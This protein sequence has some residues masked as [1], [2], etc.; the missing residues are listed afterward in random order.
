MKGF[1]LVE[2]LGVIIILGIISLIIYPIVDNSIK[3]NKESLY[4]TQLEKIKDAALGWSYTNVNMLPIDEGG[5]ITIT[6]LE[7]KKAGLVELDIRNPKTGELLPNDMIITI[8][9]KNNNYE[10]NVDGESGSD[11]TNDF[12]E[13]APILVLNGNYIEYVEI[14]DAYQDKGALAYDKNGNSVLVDVI[15]QLNGKEVGSIDTSQ[16]NTYTAIYSAT[17]NGYT[18]KIA[19]TIVIRDTTP[20]NLIVPTK[21]ELTA[22]QLETFDLLEGVTVSDNSL[23][24]I[25]IETRGFDR[26]PTDKIVEYKA[27]DSNNNCTTKRRIIEIIYVPSFATDSWET[28]RDNVKNGKAEEYYKVGDTKEINVEGYGELTVR[29]ANMT[30]P[31]E[32]L[33]EDFSQ[34]ACGFVV[35]FVNVL[36]ERQFNGTPTNDYGWP[37]SVLQ[38]YLNNEFYNKLP[39]DLQNV[40]INTKTV[41]GSGSAYTSNYIGS[42]KIYLFSHRE[43]LG[44][45]IEESDLSFEYTRQL[46]YYKLNESSPIKS[47]YYADNNY[48]YWARSAAKYDN[49]S[50]LYIT[51]TGN[52]EYK[53]ANEST[54]VSPAFRIG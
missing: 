8:T 18:S 22:V 46:D 3:E 34:T 37:E 32:C 53:Y 45:Y 19:R 20:P 49:E 27:C 14:N 21:T 40:I 54:G 39:Q 9:Y 31:S 1:T 4:N 43:I 30:T 2:V 23:E 47:I 5:T 11:I 52:L 25:N 42:E 29:I 48:S 51:S 36:E 6:L 28:I 33:Q 50:F 16:F 41:S 12:N 17:S 24:N 7:L 35:E 38:N 15:Y 44:D 26:L 10:I 13:N